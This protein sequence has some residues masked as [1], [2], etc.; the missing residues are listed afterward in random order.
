[1]LGFHDVIFSIMHISDFPWAHL[2]E[3]TFLVEV[4]STRAHTHS[5]SLER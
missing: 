5:G 4:R 2:I 1:M 3:F